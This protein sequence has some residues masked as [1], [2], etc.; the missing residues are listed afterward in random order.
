MIG[1]FS[2]L[3]NAP[4]CADPELATDR[5]GKLAEAGKLTLTEAGGFWAFGAD[6]HLKAIMH[7][8]ERSSQD[9]LRTRK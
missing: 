2:S 9:F 6:V 5:E 7:T 8:E 3:I 4:G 1:E